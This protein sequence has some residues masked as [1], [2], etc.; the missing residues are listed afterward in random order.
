MCILRICETN[1]DHSFSSGQLQ[2]EGLSNLFKL[3]RDKNNAGG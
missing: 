2:I 3:V 1:S